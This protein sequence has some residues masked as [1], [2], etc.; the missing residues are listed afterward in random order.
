MIYMEKALKGYQE[1]YDSNFVKYILRKKED[2]EYG[3]NL[4]L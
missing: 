1:S 4:I 3:F 2:Y